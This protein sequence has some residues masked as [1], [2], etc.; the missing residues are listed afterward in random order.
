MKCLRAVAIELLAFAVVGVAVTQT[1]QGQ[2][3]AAQFRLND[4]KAVAGL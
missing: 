4:G 3:A 2:A 1:G